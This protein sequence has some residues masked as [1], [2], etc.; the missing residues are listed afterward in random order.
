MGE[1]A[2]AAIVLKSISFDVLF[3]HTRP[4]GRAASQGI[5]RTIIDA[6]ADFWSAEEVKAPDGSVSVISAED[7]ECT[8]LENVIAITTLLSWFG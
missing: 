3:H 8:L 7:R 6:M 5:D 1:V 2:A 4:T